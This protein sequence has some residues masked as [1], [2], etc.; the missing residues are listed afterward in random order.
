MTA[1]KNERYNPIILLLFFLILTPSARAGLFPNAF[2]D[3][4]KSI[5]ATSK[6]VDEQ[7]RIAKTEV[8]NQDDP[9]KVQAA[10]TAAI[11]SNRATVHQALD[12][13]KA[14]ID[15]AN[16]KLDTREKLF[17]ASMVGLFISNG[18]TV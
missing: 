13:Q 15:A 11:E 18:L 4:T 16:A 17:S 5:H 9:K 8:K 1:M 3:V 10:A 7:S 6:L 14:K 12:E 2:K